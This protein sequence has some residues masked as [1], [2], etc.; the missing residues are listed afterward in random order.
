MHLLL[1]KNKKHTMSKWQKRSSRN[2]AQLKQKIYLRC[3]S[4][5]CLALSARTGHYHFTRVMPAAYV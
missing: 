3:W 5:S 2:K 4:V 1:Q